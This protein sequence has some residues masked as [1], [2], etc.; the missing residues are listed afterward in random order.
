MDD[1]DPSW[2]GLTLGGR[3]RVERALQ[4]GGMGAVY[5]AVDRNMGDRPVVVKHPLRTLGSSHSEAAEVDLR[6]RFAAEVTKLIALTDVPG[7]VRIVDQGVENG[8]PYYVMDFMAGGSLGDRL[9]ER[10]D[11]PTDVLRWAREVAETLDRIH[12]RGLVHRDIKPANL[13]FQ[14]ADEEGRACVADFGIVKELTAEW[15]TTG[16]Q[17]T[18]IGTPGFMAPEQMLLDA[19]VDGRC[20]QYALA[21]TMYVALTGRPLAYETTGGAAAKTPGQVSTSRKKLRPVN[22][23]D[24]APHVPVAAAA[25][26]AKGLMREPEDRFDTCTALVDAYEAGLQPPGTSPGLPTRRATAAEVSPTAPPVRRR[27]RR[28]AVGLLLL[29]GLGA[30]AWLGIDRLGLLPASSGGTPVEVAGGREP[31]SAPVAQPPGQTPPRPGSSTASDAARPSESPAPGLV[32]PATPVPAPAGPP[33]LLIEAPQDRTVVASRNVRVTGVVRGPLGGR[34]T[35]GEKDVALDGARFD[36][37]VAAPADGDMTLRITYLVERYMPVNETRTVLVDSQAPVIEV[38]V[39]AADVG[40]VTEATVSLEG[41]LREPHL[42]ALTV[43]GRPVTPGSGGEFRAELAL[44]A[45]GGETAVVIEATDL[46]GHTT[47]MRR[48][49]RRDA[50]RRT[51]LHVA[52]AANDVEAVRKALER[53]V[54]VNARDA[55]GKPALQVAYE[56]PGATEIIEA[57]LGGGASVRLTLSVDDPAL[58]EVN[59]RFVGLGRFSPLHV[60]AYRGDAGSVLRL[61]AAGADPEARAVLVL[62]A[63]D[64]EGRPARSAYRRRGLTALHLAALRGHVDVARAL[65]DQGA[66]PSSLDDAGRTP[67]HEAAES[68]LPG[69]A[70]LLLGAKAEVGVAD[71]SKATPLHV[72]AQN[73]EGESGDVPR[74]ELVRLLLEAGADPGAKGASDMTP[75]HGASRVDVARLLLDKGAPADAPRAYDFRT[76][77]FEAATRGA[78]DVVD[79]LISRGAEVTRAHKG[80]TLLHAAAQAQTVDVARRLLEKGLDPLAIDEDGQS[81]LFP[82]AASGSVETIRLLLDRRADVKAR[83]VKGNTPLLLA[84]KRTTKEAAELLLERG[85]D[86]AARST[87]GET[88]LQAAVGAGQTE[89][90]RLLLAKGIDAKAADGHTPKLLALAAGSG[91]IEVLQALLDLGLDPKLADAQDPSALYQACLRA[92]NLAVIRLL[93]DRGADPHGR[94]GTK[95]PLHAAAGVGDLEVAVLLL[96]KGAPLE[97]ADDAGRTPLLVA[98]AARST[99]VALELLRRGAS[100]QALDQYEQGAVRLAAEADSDELVTRLAAHGAPVDQVGYFYETTPLHEAAGRGHLEV[101]TALLAAKAGPN[102]QAQDGDTPL[103]RA[104][105]NGRAEIVAALLAGGADPRRLDE[106][107]RTPLHVAG[108]ARAVEV[109]RA[110][111]AQ[112]APLDAKDAGGGFPLHFLAGRPELAHLLLDKGAAANVKNYVGSTPLHLAARAG[113]L[114]VVR[115]LLE[116]GVP[117]DGKTHGGYSALHYAAAGTSAEVVAFLL[118]K[119]AGIDAPAYDG[120]TPFLSAA[121]TGSEAIGKML[122]ERGASLQAT[123]K[124]GLNALRRAA[125]RTNDAWV[126]L[127]LDRGLDPNLQGPSQETALQV[128][129]A[130]GQVASVQRLLEKGASPSLANAGGETPLFLAAKAG[131]LPTVAALV[132]RGADVRARTKKGRT[133]LHAAAGAESDEMA[134]LLLDKGADVGVADED[135]LTPLHD[136]AEAGSWACATLLLDRGAKIDAREKHGHTPIVHWGYSKAIIGLLLE[137]GADPRAV[138]K[139]PYVTYEDQTPLHRAVKT[140]NLK[141]VESLLAKGALIDAQDAEGKTP[142]H[143]ACELTDAFRDGV[144]RLLL[145][146]KASVKVQA[147]DGSSALHVLLAHPYGD[148]HVESV[149]ALL[150]AGADLGLRNKEGRAPVHFAC[151]LG[152]SDKASRALTFLLEKGADASAKDGKGWTPLALAASRGAAKLVVSL[153]AR[154]ADAK[155]RDSDGDTTLHAGARNA[156]VVRLLLARGADPNQRGKD[157][158]TPLHRAVTGQI[159]A[160]RLLVEHRADVNARG[161]KGRTP[162][163]AAAAG[164]SAPVVRFLLEHGA[165]LGTSD[166]EGTQPVFFAVNRLRALAALLDAGADARARDGRQ[167]TLLLRIARDGYDPLR[168]VLLCLQKGADARAK[169]K[170][171]LSALHHAAK[172]TEV[173]LATALAD[174]GGDV[175][176]TA[177]DGST[178]LHLAAGNSF[179]VNVLLDYGATVDAKRGDG[180]APLHVAVDAAALDGVARLLDAA[181]DPNSKRADGRTPLEVAAAHWDA[182]KAQPVIA[183]LL[184]RGADPKAGDK[185]G[186]TLA[187]ALIEKGSGVLAVRVMQEV[188]LPDLPEQTVKSNP[189]TTLLHVAAERAGN[190]PVVEFLLGRGASVNAPKEDQ[191][192]PLHEA[193]YSGAKD[194]ALALLDRGAQLEA[195]DDNEHTPLAKAALGGKLATFELLMARRGSATVTDKYQRTLLHLLVDGGGHDETDNLRIANLL[196]EA[197]VKMTARDN[198]GQTAL[199][200][201]RS[202]PLARFLLDHGADPNAVGTDGGTP[203]HARATFDGPVV[204]LLLERGANPNLRDKQGQTPLDVATHWKAEET[205]ALLRRAMATKR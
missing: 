48:T 28:V 135:G 31:R 86:P 198:Q 165:G 93:L 75:L 143:V 196:I 107:M 99:K 35:V 166:D 57:L 133:P 73:H 76:P 157:G 7:V 26:I 95:T 50:Q 72:A 40:A 84:A 33:T 109:V 110:L 15:A 192:T 68:G 54:P 180:S 117:I 172:R 89:T 69:V 112:G 188:G 30:A 43:D 52:V 203:L 38:I 18:H 83:D 62:R 51:A 114:D 71:P 119:G 2:V 142:L 36:T 116:A 92:N 60:A 139:G 5:R 123:D 1:R 59:G 126:R 6:K 88:P 46:A 200:D 204:A 190:A 162:L 108:G 130:L 11:S 79:L 17:N 150:A 106:W 199:H 183:L 94:A 205:A 171:G 193:A 163:H 194:V 47:S 25:A 24:L 182:A 145:R 96:D 8:T 185:G 20:D 63:R 181:A 155:G 9:R 74:A 13:L 148:D 136:A 4:A 66:S 161:G 156:A 137:R 147:K 173:P 102:L 34:L 125:K 3:Y 101:V 58:T 105:S 202:V 103:H 115:R 176:A 104:A 64:K 154:G 12:R 197:G 164:G 178:P 45:E 122:L 189:G 151:N 121:E 100:A 16:P 168:A 32:P 78:L 120:V 41:K 81:P 111:L 187:L 128:A 177:N 124:Q 10:R 22:A 152:D 70:A 61:L 153:L 91:R 149:R 14:R 134:R 85:A 146:R 131:S 138:R 37:V 87:S 56:T 27:G 49:Y 55:S 144:I 167:D 132:A 65:I 169:D 186:R 140:G 170:D 90:V 19:T 53:G 77:I 113:A 44:P 127:L 98:C 23:P 97:A 191:R 174:R 141:D 158:E 160:V 118:D 21:A 42:N 159:A 201:A 39:P 29:A 195:R 184:D 175:R 80:R 179:L 129:A 67:L 82:A